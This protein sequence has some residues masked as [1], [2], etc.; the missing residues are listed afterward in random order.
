MANVNLTDV[1]NN[2]DRPTIKAILESYGGVLE[3]DS[4]TAYTEGRIVSVNGETFI[5]CS[6][7]AGSTG[8]DPTADDGTN[9]LNVFGV[10]TVADDIT[11]FGVPLRAGTL[12]IRADNAQ[13]YKADSV[14][15]ATDTIFDADISVVED[16]GAV[17]NTQ[18]T[19][20]QNDVAYVPGSGF[21]YCSNAA[22][23]TGDDPTADDGTNWLNVADIVTVATASTAYGVPLRA[24][25]LIIQIS[26]YRIFT[27]DSVLPATNTT[28]DGSVTATA[29]LGVEQAWEDVASSRAISTPYQN[30]TGVPIQVAIELDTGASADTTVQ[31]SSNGSTWWTIGAEST[32]GPVN[33]SFIVPNGHYY[34]VAGGTATINSWLEL[35]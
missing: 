13:V 20:D 30:S 18:A 1:L 2:E 21:A 6:N 9:W 22:G 34:Q 10:H 33:V 27:A 31:V 24:G 28:S 5:I 16:K 15:A 19:Y 3:W 23:S 7:A 17:W 26:P 32:T 8:D 12:I 4:S 35:R 14:L 29:A 11:A 25:T